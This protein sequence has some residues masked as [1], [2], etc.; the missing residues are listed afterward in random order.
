MQSQVQFNPFYGS[1]EGSDPNNYINAE[2]RLQGDRPH[3][4]RVQG[5]VRLP[6]DVMF[7]ASLDLSSGRA[8]NRQIRVRGLGQGTAT[9]IME[10][11]GAYRFDPLRVVDIVVGKRVKVGSKANLK[12]DAYVYNLLNSETE[13]FFSTLRI[14]APGEDF[15]ADTWWKPRRLML[16]AGFDF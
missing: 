2:G 13:L 9:V 6:G 4:F 7:S 3:M 5:V 8:H 10:P 14:Q 11:S 12:F 1:K 16:R 15:V